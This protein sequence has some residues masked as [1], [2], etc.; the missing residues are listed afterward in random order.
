MRIATATV[1]SG[2][3]LLLGAVVGV[4]PGVS[5]T[6]GITALVA[7]SFALAVALEDRSRDE[8]PSPVLAQIQRGL[9]TD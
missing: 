6:V 1:L 7:G 2:L 5:F 4:S 3:V 8:L 9:D